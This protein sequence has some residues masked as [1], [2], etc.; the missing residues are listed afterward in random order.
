MAADDWAEQ[1]KLALDADHAIRARRIVAHLVD[2][3]DTRDLALQILAVQAAAGSRLA[4]ELLTEVVDDIGLARAAVRKVLVDESTVDD[5]AQ[6]VLIAMA[7]SITGYR[8]ESSFVTWLF[9]IGRNR[10]VDYLR[11]Q[12][13]HGNHTGTE[14]TNSHRIRPSTDP[15]DEAEWTEA[16][17][18]SSLIT[19][20]QSIRQLVDQLP[21]PYRRAVQLRELAHLS[22]AEIADRLSLNLNTVRS[23]IGRGRALMARMIDAD[24][25][26]WR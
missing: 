5:V 1:L 2:T 22:Y 7:R 8:A 4:V 10:S 19:S 17:R 15:L 16:Y 25:E 18:I 6:E 24:Q 12:R 26:G 11:R 21:E 20:R 9:Q 13:A 3:R 14:T 23:H